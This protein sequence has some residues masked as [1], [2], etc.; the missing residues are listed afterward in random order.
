MNAMKARRAE[1]AEH[2]SVI[3]TGISLVRAVKTFPG[4]RETA[5]PRI[6]EASS[7]N[8]AVKE[9]SAGPSAINGRNTTGHARNE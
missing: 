8:P 3:T 5:S 9:T 2:W 4:D 6:V 7:A 1:S